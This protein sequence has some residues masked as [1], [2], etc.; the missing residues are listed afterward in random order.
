M[1]KGNLCLKCSVQGRCCFYSVL[2]EGYNII[3]DFQP[4]EFLDLE[5]KLCKNFDERKEIF[6]YCKDTTDSNSGAFPKEC[7]FLKENPKLESNPKVDVRGVADKLTPK[8]L[9]MY[10]VLNNIK[11]RKELRGET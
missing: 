6:E 2:I 3:L 4:C 7:L 1:N 5:T 10:N 9:M 8:G 11:D